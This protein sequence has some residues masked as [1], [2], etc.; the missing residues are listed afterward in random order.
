MTVTAVFTNGILPLIAVY[1]SL[2]C[3]M[4]SLSASLP[5]LISLCRYLGAACRWIA[6]IINS[7]QCCTS[8]F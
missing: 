1:H 8:S 6:R 5:P 7:V 4:K 3:D 2:S